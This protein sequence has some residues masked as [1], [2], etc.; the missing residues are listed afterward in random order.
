MGGHGSGGR[1]AGAGRKKK[2]EHLRLIDGGAGRR[3]R[4]STGDQA[5]GAEDAPAADA[6]VLEP[7]DTL[8]AEERAVWDEWAPLA[9]AA[10]T[11]TSTTLPNFVTL[12]E[13]EADRR[14]L[15]GRYLRAKV[16]KT[17]EPLPLVFM[18]PDEELAFRREHRTLA[19]DIHSRCKDFAIAP[20]GKEIDAGAGAA[21]AADPLDAFTRRR[22]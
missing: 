13:L 10:R 8:L 9:L 19:K 17:G 22:G 4:R 6:P 12:C 7:P 15:R 11:L 18:E 2:A 5:I 3:G 20:F 14:D 21:A 16:K 1:R